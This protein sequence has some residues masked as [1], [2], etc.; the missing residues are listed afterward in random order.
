MMV[1]WCVVR[2]AYR[3][4]HGA[5]KKQ[6]PEAMKHPERTR[7]VKFGSGCWPRGSKGDAMRFFC[8]PLNNE[9]TD[10]QQRPLG[11]ALN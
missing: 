4:F 2:I 6:L 3:A 8:A 5:V 9:A 7:F 11:T 1:S 10:Q